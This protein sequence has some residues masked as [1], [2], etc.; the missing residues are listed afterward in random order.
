MPRP[1]GASS[2]NWT[3]TDY[4]RLAMLITAITVGLASGSNYVYSGYAPQLASQL[5]ITSTQV[6]LVGLAGNVGMYLSGPLWGKIV[7]ARGSRIPLLIAGLLNLAGYSLLHAFY[8]GTI[9][10]RSAPGSPV[11]PINFTLMCLTLTMT[12]FGGSAGLSASMNAVAKSYPDATRAS[13]SGM[14]LAGFGLSAFMFSTLGQKI[15]HGEAG[16]LLFL[17]TI[18]TSAPMLIGSFIVRAIPS[19]AAGAGLGEGYSPIRMEAGASDEDIATR[20]S[21]ESPSLRVTRSNSLEL[22]RSISPPRGRAPHTHAHFA[23]P[24]SGSTTPSKLPSHIRSSSFASLSP[25]A[26]SLQPMD[27]LFSLD[28]GILFATLALLCGMG[29]MYINNVGTVALVLGRKGEWGYDSREISRWQAKQVGTVSIWN[30]L[31][32]IFGG[33]GSDL[34]KSKLKMRRVSRLCLW[35]PETRDKCLPS[36]QVWFLPIIAMAFILAQQLALHVTSVEHLWIVS[37]ILGFAYGAL[38]NVLPMLTLEYFGMAHFSQNWGWTCVAPIIGGNLFNIVFGRV[39]DSN[40]VNEPSELG[41]EYGAELI[42]SV[43]KRGGVSLPGDTH[44]CLLGVPCYATAFKVS[45]WGAV[46]ALMLSV[47]VGIR[48]ER[49]SRQ[50]RREL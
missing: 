42:R 1:A 18:G 8:T 47:W 21:Y 19:E 4:R 13:A 23:D 28:F 31:G 34:C 32:R 10:I 24:T 49:Q 50:R 20:D 38:F 45:T 2:P 11:L 15:Y 16:G 22:S 43:L 26:I 37:T 3:I 35:G 29:L 41:L 30:C 9:P 33:L 14:V 44:D 36:Y 6:N 40:T 7:D 46:I 5:H 27:L 48:K 12:G 39:Y 25:T 17:L